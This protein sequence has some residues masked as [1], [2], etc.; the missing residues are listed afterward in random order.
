[1]FR[2]SIQP[3][4]NVL[5]DWLLFFL[6]KL[7]YIVS[8][9]YFVVHRSFF[10]GGGGVAHRAVY[11]VVLDVP[12]YVFSVQLCGEN[13][14]SQ[15]MTNSHVSWYFESNEIKRGK[16]SC[17]SRGSGLLWL[18]S[19]TRIFWDKKRRAC[20]VPGVL[21]VQISLVLV[22]IL[23]LTFRRANWIVCSIYCAMRNVMAAPVCLQFRQSINKFMVINFSFWF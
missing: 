10:F 21:T 18:V 1:M 20:S 14:I 7:L 8:T 6:V 3:H 11:P 17:W 5:R 16:W 4:H 9:T 15:Y 23:F 2:D 22:C 13:P 12:R 19:Q